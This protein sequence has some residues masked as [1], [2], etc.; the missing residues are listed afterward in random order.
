MSPCRFFH[1]E[2]LSII[3]T[4]LVKLFHKLSSFTPFSSFLFE[5][6]KNTKSHHFIEA[7]YISGVKM[8]VPR[9]NKVSIK[10]TSRYDTSFVHLISC[11]NSEV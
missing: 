6:Y 7:I 3:F 1:L 11:L 2:Q 10:L 9:Y 4:S 5:I 8:K